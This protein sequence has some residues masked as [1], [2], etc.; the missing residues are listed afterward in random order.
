MELN[1]P[2]NCQ[3]SECEKL[4]AEEHLAKL[5]SLHG[6]YSSEVDRKWHTIGEIDLMIELQ[7]FEH[8]KSQTQ[9]SH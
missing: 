4:R 9:R 8:E 2:K 5:R 1:H 7:L 3:C 6:S